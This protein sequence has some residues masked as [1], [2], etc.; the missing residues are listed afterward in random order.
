MYHVAE[1][2]VANLNTA[3]L[4][5]A[6]YIILLGFNFYV[7]QKFNTN[8]FSLVGG[9]PKGENLLSHQ[10]LGRSPKQLLIISIQAY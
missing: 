6:F 3:Y 7:T 2:K 9:V 10:L 4:Y 1:D 8:F 5:C